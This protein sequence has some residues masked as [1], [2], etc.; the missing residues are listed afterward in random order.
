MSPGPFSHSS[1]L[2]RL[3]EEGYFVQIRGGLLILRELPYVT[4]SQVI[5]TGTLISSLSL[6][7]DVT[8]PPDSHQVWFDGEFP[9]D[10]NGA[11][12]TGIGNG[13][14]DYDLGHGLTAKF[15]FSTR[16]DGGYPDYYEK[17]THYA[18]LLAGPAAN[19]KP[20]T[21]ARG[22]RSPDEED[23]C[24]FNYTETASDRVGIGALTQRL[25][26]ETIAIIGLG[27]TGSYIL[28]FVAKTPVREIRL[29]DQDEFLQHNAFRAPGAPSIEELREAP[30]KVQYLKGIYSKMHRGIIAHETRIDETNVGLLDGVT[31]AFLCMDAGEAKRQIVQKLESI[32]D[33]FIDVGMGLELEEGSLGGILR[34]TASTPEKREHVKERVSFDD[35]AANDIYASNI[36]VADLNALNA[37]LAVIK[38]KKLRGF[39]RDLEQE[40]HC[41]YTTD[42]NMLLNGDLP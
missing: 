42:G 20:G 21:T 27:G 7:G 28:D 24:V 6:A 34:V 36:Q 40:H 9:C 22:F 29:F 10:A 17:M 19:L 31:F 14:Q 33:S 11:P 18:N 30:S 16:P 15:H 12:L 25:A 26:G 5:K 32:G 39:Y 2:K 1:D 13:G 4:A 3:R 38:W 35:G 37:V 8:K 23:D 41:T